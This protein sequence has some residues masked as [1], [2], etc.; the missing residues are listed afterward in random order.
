MIN[1]HI[2]IKFTMN[3]NKNLATLSLEVYQ[4]QDIIYWAQIQNMYEN[5][6]NELD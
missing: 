2:L 5:I 1:E 4:L 6:L 3:D